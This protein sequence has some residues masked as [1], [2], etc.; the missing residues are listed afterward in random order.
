MK[1]HRL[2]MILSIST[3]LL[4]GACSNT[5]ETFHVTYANA[6][7]AFYISALYVKTASG[8]WSSSYIPAGE[9]VSPNYYFEFD[10]PLNMGESVEYYITV[11]NALAVTEDLYLD[12]QGN[13]LAILQWAEAYRHQF[14]TVS[15][16]GEGNPVVTAHGGDVWS[17]P[18]DN[19][20]TKVSWQ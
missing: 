13:D 9:L 15:Q 12:D 10:I 20:Y 3:F 17:N 1:I 19:G 4:F 7:S 11:R 6:S 18:D 8:G 5:T 14:I 16:N 2:V